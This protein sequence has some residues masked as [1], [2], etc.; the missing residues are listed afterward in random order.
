MVNYE[1]ADCGTT[2]TR[3]TAY[4]DGDGRAVCVECYEVWY[5]STH[6]EECGYSL[7]ECHCEG[8]P[9]ATE[10]EFEMIPLYIPEFSEG[11]EAVVP[12]DYEVK[13][14]ENE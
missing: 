6:C 3:K 10:E 1:C 11:E 4:W 7:D 13:E 2:L 9:V 12:Y 8:E 5:E 14:D